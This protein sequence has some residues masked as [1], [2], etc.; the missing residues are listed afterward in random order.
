MDDSNNYNA[1][2]GLTSI[3]EGLKPFIDALDKLNTWYEQ[4]AENIASYLSVFA[5][6]AEW[7]VA[8][9]KLIENQFVFTDDLT[10]ELAHDI[11]QS[12]DVTEVMDRYYFGNSEQNINKLIQR[13][14]NNKNIGKYRELYN[15]IIN[16][17]IRGDYLIACIGLFSLVDGVLAEH[18][19]INKTGF[20]KRLDRIAKKFASKA[21][22]NEIDRKTLCIYD[23]F[24]KFDCSV[25]QKSDFAQEEPQVVNRHWDVHGRTHRKHT[26]IDFLKILLWLDAIMYLSQKD[27]PLEMENKSDE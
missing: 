2:E 7:S 5:E 26:K 23:A 9:E 25:F 21:E 6:Y 16:A 22:L 15:Q 14:G 13:C 11:Y 10:P 3:I 27:V 8:V 18:S 12:S 19:G 4:N 1:F 24:T 20:Q 17:Y